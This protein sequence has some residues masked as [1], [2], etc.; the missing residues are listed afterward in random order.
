MCITDVYGLGRVQIPES[1]T[2]RWIWLCHHAY[3]P[4]YEIVYGRRAEG[5]GGKTHGAELLYEAKAPARQQR[6][7]GGGLDGQEMPP[8]QSH[9]AKALDDVPARPGLRR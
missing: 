2:S 3:V 6:G 9:D 1:S 4:T 7:R 5:E 8:L